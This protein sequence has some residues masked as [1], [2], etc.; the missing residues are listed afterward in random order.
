MVS[1]II[2]ACN[3]HKFLIR[4]LNSIRRQT[5]KDIE[6]IV[7]ANDNIQKLVQNDVKVIMAQSFCKGLKEAVETAAGNR[8]YLCSSTSVITENVISDLFEVASDSSL[9]TYTRGYIRMKNDYAPYMGI[10]VSLYGKLMDKDILN[11]ALSDNYSNQADITVSYMRQCKGVVTVDGAVL[12]ET[13]TESEMAQMTME[14]VKEEPL[15]NFLK[16]ACDA[17]MEDSVRNYITAGIG[18]IIAAVV[19]ETDD[20]MLYIKNVMPDDMWLNYSVSRKTIS[21]WWNIIQNGNNTKIY[22]AFREYISS[23]ND[24]LIKMMLKD[25]GINRAIFEIMK[26]NE[27]DVFLNIYNGI[28]ND[29]G[30]AV[31]RTVAPAQNNSQGYSYELSGMQLADYVVDKYRS[32]SLGLKTFFKSFGAWIKFKLK[33]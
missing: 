32:G 10:N 9:C 4:S 21:R 14:T 26:V 2:D 22:N 31:V 17:G 3:G 20:M 33:R 16:K 19:E 28:K 7:V 23:F 5:Y 13:C 29:T 6:I 12:Y 30:V 8:I 18:E 15:R 1:V 24:E 27:Q 25:C 11:K